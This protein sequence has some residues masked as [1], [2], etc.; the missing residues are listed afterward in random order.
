MINESTIFKQNPAI[1]SASQVLGCRDLSQSQSSLIDKTKT[2]VFD[3]ERIDLEVTK[4]NPR[5]DYKNLK[6]MNKKQFD[7]QQSFEEGGMQEMLNFRRRDSQ[8]RLQAYSS[9][10]IAKSVSELEPSRNIGQSQSQLSGDD[11][12]KI[13][14]EKL[15]RIALN[16]SMNGI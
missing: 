8:Q 15:N 9:Q 5:V 4:P 14:R 12:S 10:N 13:I 11:Y 1:Q 2:P 16:K 3:T 7:L 6:V